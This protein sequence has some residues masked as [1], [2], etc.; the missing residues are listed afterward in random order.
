MKDGF[1]AW[2]KAYPFITSAGLNPLLTKTIIAPRISTMFDNAT[3]VP[4]IEVTFVILFN[5]KSFPQSC[6]KHIKSYMDKAKKWGYYV[7]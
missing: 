1:C 6:G 3:T 2:T 5:P 4:P 7:V